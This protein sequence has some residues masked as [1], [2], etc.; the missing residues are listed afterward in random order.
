MKKVIFKVLL[1]LV[2]I[3]SFAQERIITPLN[4]HYYPLS[5]GGGEHVFNRVESKSSDGYMIY[6]I[7][8]LDNILIKVNRSS[9]L[10]V[11]GELVHFEEEKS[12]NSSGALNFVRLDFK[13]SKST[14]V[15]ILV[16]EDV[17]SEIQCVNQN[18]CSGFLVLP[19]GEELAIDRDIFKPS[20]TDAG[21]FDVWLSKVLTYPIVSRRLGVQ[22]DVWVG[23]EIDENGDLIQFKIMN[24]NE[25]HDSLIDEVNRV[26]RKYK[27]GFIPAKNLK[28]EAIQ[29]W[30][31]FPVKFR[32]G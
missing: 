4:D 13:S 26:L 25:V 8:T 19:D 5:Q 1:L 10:Q 16:D 15:K 21:V 29:A 18:D 31:Y 30:M 28:G 12:Y 9:Y 3:G 24:K 17:V 7:F 6:R 23:A 32:L 2:S 11:D 20:F 14:Q 27:D 22:G